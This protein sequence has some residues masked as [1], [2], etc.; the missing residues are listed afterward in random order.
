MIGILLA[1]AAASPDV[2]AADK[3]ADTCEAAR[4]TTFGQAV[5]DMTRPVPIGDPEAMRRWLD[6]GKHDRT[7]YEQSRRMLL[8][9][10]G[11]TQSG[12]PWAERF[13]DRMDGSMLKGRLEGIGQ[14]D[15]G[16]RVV[17]RK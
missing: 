10:I 15:L 13:C 16:V 4:Q 8:M 11:V 7:V 3:L 17:E 2:L 5:F 12:L 6:A 1:L 9:S 14:R